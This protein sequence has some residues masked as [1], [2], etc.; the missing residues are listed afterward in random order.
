MER[1]TN[2][3]WVA[4]CLTL[5]AGA[6]AGYGAYRLSRAARRSCAVILREH[7]SLFDLWTWEAP[8]TVLAAG[9]TGL[10]AWA[11]PAGVLRHQKRRY[12]NLLIPPAVFLAALIA[13]TLVHFAWL[14]TPLGVGNDTNGN[15]PLDNVPP[16][17]P[18]WLPT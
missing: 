11:L 14:G 1:Q 9:F 13:L 15:C 6:L 12:L 5:L 10:A 17:W 8:L 4:G 2:P 3:P 18:E 16:W 7:P